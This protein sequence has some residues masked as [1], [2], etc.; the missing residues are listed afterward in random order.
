MPTLA[1][2][3]DVHFGKISDARVVAALVAEVNAAGHALVVV[4]GDLTQRARTTQFRAARAMLDAFDAPTLVV[5][6]NHDVRAWWHNPFERVW[7]S[8]KRFR[9]HITEDETPSFEAPGLSAF[10]LNSAHGLTIKGGRIRTEHVAEMEAFFAHQPPGA[11]RVLTLHHHLLLLDGLGDHDVSRGARLALDAAQRARVDLILCGH[12]HRSHV[13]PIELAPSGDADGH[14]VVI[15]SAGTATSNR[16]RGEDRAAN[17]Y[18]WVTVGE[19]SFAVAERRFDAET[20]RFEQ[21]RTTT[22]ARDRRAGS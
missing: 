6:G 8:S 4:S 9:Q 13:A 10:G 12:L 14:R 7:R 22:F 2:L 20:G 21:E 1:H 15:A 3:S 18:N 17:F 16:G 19:E 5:P 11:F